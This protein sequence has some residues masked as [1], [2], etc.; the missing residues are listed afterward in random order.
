VTGDGS[1]VMVS[2]HTCCVQ[3]LKYD[4]IHL[5]DNTVEA[6]GHLQLSKQSVVVNSV[7]HCRQVKQ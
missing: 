4:A 1:D 2:V 7:E 6:L 5:K 3:P